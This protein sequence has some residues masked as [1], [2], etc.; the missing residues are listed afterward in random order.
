[1]KD[2]RNV[3]LLEVAHAPRDWPD[4]L[5]AAGL[6]PAALRKRLSFDYSAYAIQAALDG[7][8]VA[9]ARQPYVSDDLAAGRL[10]KPFNLA[11]EDATRGWHLIYQQ[12]AREDAAFA[13]FRGWLLG[14]V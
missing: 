10:V 4:W 14:V 8:G 2:L 9:L 5:A 3:A 6:D 11:Y 12:T 13:T 1:M 7:L